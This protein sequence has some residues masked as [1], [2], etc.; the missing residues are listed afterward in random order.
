MKL[1][2]ERF[3]F[4]LILMLTVYNAGA[5]QLNFKQL[6]EKREKI[7]L[8]EAKNSEREVSS[9]TI[10]FNDE[11]V[12]ISYDLKGD[13]FIVLKATV[14]DSGK[15]SFDHGLWIDP[16]IIDSDGNSFPVNEMKAIYARSGWGS[17]RYNVQNGGNVCKVK[18]VTYP[19]TIWMHADG[20]AVF[21]LPKNAVKFTAK[22]ALED[23]GKKGDVVFKI[24]SESVGMIVK[25]NV[26]DVDSNFRAIAGD[27][28]SQ[29]LS[30]EG[31]S[32]TDKIAERLFS[33]LD[34]RSYFDSKYQKSG[35]LSESNIQLLFD[36]TA[37][38]SLQGK[39]QNLNLD[40][41]IRTIEAI[42][43]DNKG[44]EQ[45]ANSAISEAN[46]FKKVLSNLKSDIYSNDSAAIAKL[47]RF[48]ESQRANLLSNPILEG[49]EILT[50]RQVVKNS[51]TAMAQH[52]GRNLN[53][54]TTSSE[55]K[56]SG[57]NNEIV[58]LSNLSGDIKFTTVYK[59]EGTK[60][61]KDF[62][63][64]WD[65]G[66]LLFSTVGENNRWHVFEKD[67]KTEEVVRLSPD[68][69][70]DVDFYDPCY[71]P[72]GRV[73]LASN[74]SYVAVPCIGGA[75][76]ASD[77]YLLDPSIEMNKRV[78]QLNFGQ[79]CDWNPVVLNNGKVCYLRWEY[80]DNSHYFT[81]IL[82]NMNPDGTAKKELY[83][84]GSY[85]PNSLFDVRPIPNNATQFVG[86]VSGHHGI[87]R[88]GRLMIFDTAK[89]R[90]EADG[91]VQE[92]PGYGKVVEPIIKDQL[93]NG[94]WPQFLN[95]YPLSEDY[96]I[97]TGKLTPNSLWGLYLV[98]KNDNMTLIH[99]QEG[100]AYTEPYIFSAREKAPSIPDRVNLKDDEATI[101]ISD[102]YE[103]VGLKGV[104]KGTIKKL[105]VY[106]Y[107]YGYNGV[108]GH[109]VM[110]IESCWDVKRLLGTVPVEEDGSAHFKV[111]ANT[112]IAVHPIDEEGRAR[113]LMRSWMTGMPGEIVSCVGC[114]EPQDMA[115]PARRSIAQT[116]APATL[117]RWKGDVRPYTFANEM[118]PLLE[119][120]C[121]GCHDGQ[122]E[123]RPNFADRGPSGLR[124]FANDYVALHPYV[125]RP[126]SESDF[127]TLE[128]MDYMANTSELV[129][130]LKKGH[131]GVEMDSDDWERLYTWIDLNVPFEGSYSP[132]TFRGNDQVQR[133]DELSSCY[134]NV[135]LTGESELEKA[136]KLRAEKG[137]EE[138]I[139]PAKRQAKHEDVE[140]KGWPFDEA[141]ALAMQKKAAE[142]GV[143]KKTIKLDSGLSIEL[144]RIPAGKYVIGDSKGEPDQKERVVKIKK[145]FW[146]SSKEITNEIFESVFEDHDSRFIDQQWKDHIFAGYPA[147]KPEMPAIRMSWDRATEF[148]NIIGE[149]LDLDIALPTETQWEWAARG[150]SDKSAYYGDVNSNFSS[151]ENLADYTLRDLA[152]T[153]VDPKPMST[154]S[155]SF[156]YYNFVPK[157]EK[158]NDGVLVPEGTGMYKPNVWGL[159][160]MLGNV[161]EWTSSSYN[162]IGGA[163]EVEEG[164]LKTVRGGSW[165]D[166]P[167]YATAATRDGYLSYQKVYNVG[168]RIV[169]NE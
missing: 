15:N 7:Q 156:K 159:Y 56:K 133:R 121:I 74:A 20:E 107:Q 45:W 9:K 99:E 75:S 40:G 135:L 123:G 111:P 160:D 19:H 71:L 162:Y 37:V 83:G 60:P 143:I 39:L 136:N 125:R 23:G 21:E 87:A 77:L 134:G 85:F 65:A 49:K 36:A 98:D 145:A 119:K 70:S 47:N 64:D 153:G 54:W 169:I 120:R 31:R 92:I 129:Q 28:Y 141:T 18:G 26:D 1:M 58:K 94:V 144:V 35:D 165:R 138:F 55:V 82:M 73:I 131:Y 6:F 161:S 128:P 33:K 44:K 8:I 122:K 127:H 81:R 115:P 108:G 150:G 14:G 38:L 17:V 5:E 151:Y 80:T 43:K 52:I 91:V 25:D 30:L 149:Q 168:F 69:Q 32:I 51:R 103:G 167:R 110:G 130:I 101:M 27:L 41:Y 63:L 2:R 76:P 113:Q 67:L 89:G 66:K 106:A 68:N 34:D 157:V 46:D 53:N 104:P 72:D 164:E 109:N 126:G 152:V 105:R 95:P 96:F 147:N 59:P 116:K 4:S 3:L 132:P 118:R 97:V 114:H 93:V 166:R 13:K 61:V 29:W 146:I 10:R 148:C 86:V 163:E 50:I 88:S 57:W 139:R 158:Y 137:A 102:I 117:T 124:D 155:F 142:K 16:T 24:V 12:E 62:D 42:K 90:T 84:S 154:K 100:E 78:R 79:D 22:V 112:P 48:I 140:L 11:P